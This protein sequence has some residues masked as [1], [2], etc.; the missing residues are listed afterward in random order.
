VFIVYVPAINRHEV[1]REC[2]ENMAKTVSDKEN[3]LLL[4]ID[5]EST[6][7]YTKEEFS[8]LDIRLDVIRNDEAKSCYYSITQAD[9]Y[10]RGLQESSDE[11]IVAFI[12]NDLLIYEQGW[13]IR[14]RK[15]FEADPLLKLI[16]FAGSNEVCSR[17]GRGLGTVTNFTSTPPL[18]RGASWEH[19]GG[20]TT[21]LVPAVSLDS[22][23]MIFRVTALPLL[24]IDETISPCHFYDKIWT[25]KIVSKG[26]RAAILGIQVEHVGSQTSG[27]IVFAH[28]CQ[29]WCKENGIE[30]DPNNQASDGGGAVY[31]ESEKRYFSEFGPSGYIPCRVDM[32]YNVQSHIGV[33]TYP[34]WYP[35]VEIHNIPMEERIQKG[36]I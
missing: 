2:V 17:G 34:S 26:H 16:G 9:A 3:F 27:E 14:I 10:R 19:A 31:R 29:R 13:D 7:P 6:E 36:L 35:N 11:D 1:T 8:D 32:Q 22:L 21:D 4:I 5:N 23:A 33:P 28:Q 20:L 25:L 15:S 12:H 24:D 30:V 18:F